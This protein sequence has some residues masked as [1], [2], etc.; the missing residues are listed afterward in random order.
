MHD[1]QPTRS[2]PDRID[3][4]NEPAAETDLLANQVI[5]AAIEVHRILG[6][7]FLESTYE[8]AL[9]HEFQLR[10]IP[11]ERQAPVG[12]TYKGAPIGSRILDLLVGKRLIVELKSAE[13]LLP[14]HTA[15]LVSYLRATGLELGLLIN[16]NCRLLKQGIRRVVN[17]L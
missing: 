10:G 15:Q 14:I 17:T 5:G 16:F 9:A 2:D 1:C 12:V 7:G 4:L 11:F 3:G 8:E 6:P 13:A